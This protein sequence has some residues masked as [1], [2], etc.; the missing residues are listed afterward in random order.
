MMSTT[1]K[2]KSVKVHNIKEA[3][4]YAEKALGVKYYATHNGAYGP[5]AYWV[6][7]PSRPSYFLSLLCFKRDWFHSFARI[8]PKWQGWGFGQTMNLD[9]LERAA[10]RS[11]DILIVMAEGTI[12]SYPANAWLTLARQ[13]GSIR[14]PTG[15]TE[16]EA[17]IPAKKLKRVYPK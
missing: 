1:D 8:F 17:S 5:I 15:E 14:I 7:D 2:Q 6:R 3:L 11:S 10:K 16:Y 9:G 12:Y 4:A 13:F